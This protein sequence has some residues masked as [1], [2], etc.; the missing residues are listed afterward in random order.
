MRECTSISEIAAL[1]PD[2]MGF[3]FYL[4][5]PR[6][7][8]A[9]EDEMVQYA[10]SQGIEPVAVFVNASL[11]TMIQI[12]DL[13]GF[14]HIQLHGKE[15]P[16]VCKALKEK[17]VKVLKAFSIADSSDLETVQAYDQCCD[18]FLF[19]TKTA[20]HG[21]SGCQFDWNILNAYTG[22]T[23]FFLSGGIGPD[24]VEQ[25]R[26]FDHPMLFGIDL[27][28]RF[29]IQPAQKDAALLRKFMDQLIPKNQET[30]A[31]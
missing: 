23:P 1:K 31:K 25:I 27:N 13:Y 19:D 12:V 21:G 6:F 28:S 3:I 26:K 30:N 17:G 18:Y 16:E 11:M 8:G 10:K 22:T 14:T 15:T 20:I 4:K 29:E 24:D 5:S 9:L 7:V 2:F